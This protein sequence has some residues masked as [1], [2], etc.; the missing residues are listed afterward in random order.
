MMSTWSCGFCPEAAILCREGGVI[1]SYYAWMN[2][3]YKHNQLKEIIDLAEVTVLDYILGGDYQKFLQE[4]DQIKATKALS[5]AVNEIYGRRYVV[6]N[7]ILPRMV[8]AGKYVKRA[9]NDFI[10]LCG[11]TEDISNMNDYDLSEY[12]QI[13]G[14]KY[15][16]L[17][18][19]RA[20]TEKVVTI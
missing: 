7:T 17:N 20:L 11:G 14:D 12:L 15:F 13:L 10:R 3:G 8:V 18:E 5:E 16:L 9:V 2:N 1:L 19:V 6:L 4:Y